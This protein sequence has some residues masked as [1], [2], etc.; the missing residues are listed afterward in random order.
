MPGALATLKRHPF[1]VS[2]HFDK[3][4]AVSFAFPCEALRPLVPEPLEIDAFEG[5]RGA[6]CLAQAARFDGGHG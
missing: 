1:P 5:D 6:V 2:A 3:V 4:L